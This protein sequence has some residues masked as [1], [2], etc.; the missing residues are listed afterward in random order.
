MAPGFAHAIGPR[1]QVRR[2]ERRRSCG[3]RFR[4][5]DAVTKLGRHQHAHDCLANRFF[6]VQTSLLAPGAVEAE[7]F[8]ALRLR[9][10]TTRGA[11]GEALKGSEVARFRS[12]PSLFHV[13]NLGGDVLEVIFNGA[14]RGALPTVA[15]GLGEVGFGEALDL[16]L[17]R[18]VLIFGAS[19]IKLRTLR[20][21]SI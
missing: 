15:A 20:S 3:R 2:R 5:V 9:Q 8:S 12:Q 14:D 19:E 10:R 11:F 16:R 6:V 4:K 18:H 1:L 7:K 17:G 21:V 13:P